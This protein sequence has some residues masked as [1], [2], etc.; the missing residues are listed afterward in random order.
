MKNTILTIKQ[1]CFNCLH[2][3]EG[4]CNFKHPNGLSFDVMKIHVNEVTGEKY[5]CGCCCRNYIHINPK[6]M[7]IFT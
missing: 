1:G 7:V 4:E 3:K 2:H 6:E 5:R